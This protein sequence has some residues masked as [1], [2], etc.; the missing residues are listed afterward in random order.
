MAAPLTLIIPLKHGADIEKLAGIL[1]AQQ[2]AIDAA[3]RKIATIHY[4]RFLIYDHSAPNLQP[5][6][7]S[8]GPF[9]LAVITDFDGD[10]DVYIQDFINNLGPAFSLLLGYSADG[11]DIVPPSEHVEEFIAYIKRNDASQQGI[12]SNLRFY[13]AYPDTVQQ[14]LANSTS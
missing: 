5:A 7:G 10:F 6:P 9:S 4:A 3:R 1:V 13:E 2:D 14:V 8:S 11:A 12:N